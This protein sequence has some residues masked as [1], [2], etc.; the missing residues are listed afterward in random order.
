MGVAAYDDVVVVAVAFV[1]DLAMYF[2]TSRAGAGGSTLVTADAAAVADDDDGGVAEQ[3]GG[4]EMAV[5]RG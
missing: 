4:M 1:D 5:D 3:E 2:G